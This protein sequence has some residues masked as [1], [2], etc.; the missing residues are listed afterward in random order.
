MIPATL[1]IVRN[2]PILFYNPPVLGWADNI[3]GGESW[4]GL[5]ITYSQNCVFGRMVRW[6]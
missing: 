5:G 3:T 1:P 4:L 6:R 2:N